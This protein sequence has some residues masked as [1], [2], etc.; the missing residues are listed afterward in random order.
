MIMQQIQCCRLIPDAPSGCGADQFLNHM[1]VTE[2][3]DGPISG[4]LRCETCSSVYFFTTVAWSRSSFV[5]VIA[6]ASVPEDSWPRLISFFGQTPSGR[7]WIPTMLSRPS[8][9]ELD[10]IEAFLGSITSEA[11]ATTLLLAWDITLSSVLAV[12]RVNGLPT[13][14]DLNLLA[15]RWSGAKSAADWFA[16][17][18]MTP[19]D[20]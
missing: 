16:D 19:P 6:L 13:P 15:P 3:Y 5:R 10:Q 11:G 18:G 1:L 20:R 17:L 2:Y 7:H 9:E 4:F 14:S 8:E 12:R